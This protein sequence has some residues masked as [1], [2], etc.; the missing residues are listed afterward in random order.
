MERRLAAILSYDI[1]GYSRAMG[2]DEHGTLERLKAHRRDVIE[3]KAA[4]HGGRI[5]KLMG[6]GALMEFSSVVDAVGF[7]VQV[8]TTV[9]GRDADLTEDQRLRYRIGINIGDVIAE[10]DDIYGDGVNVAVRLERLAKAGGVCVRRNVRNQVRGKLALDFE[11][12]GEI[13]FKNIERPVRVF[14]LLMNAK[15]AALAAALDEIPPAAKSGFR[16]SINGALS[17]PDKPSI[18]V[19]PFDNMSGDPGQ[20]YF[21]DG[22]TEEIITMLG[23]CRWLFVVARNS[24][25]AYKGKLIDIRRIAEEL[26][27]RY[28]LEGSVRRSGSRIRIK[29]ELV[30]GRDGAHLWGER[31][32]RDISDIFDLQDEIASIIAGTLEPELSSIEGAAL[33]GR[34]TSDLNAWDCYQRGLWHLYHF[35]KGDLESA[36]A[37]FDRAIALDPSF[38]LAHAKLAYTHIQLGWYGRWEDRPRRIADAISIARQAISLDE[39]EPAARVS[40]GRALA[41]SGALDRGEEELRTAVALDP[42]FAQAHFALAQALCFLERPDE[43]I[44]EVNEAIQLSPRD[45][46]MW[47]FLNVRAI[48]H[49]QAGNLEAAEEDERTALRQPNTTFIPARLLAAILGRQG[50]R[51]EAKEA[52][53]EL[54]RLRPGYTCA[55][56][57]R[58]WYFGPRPFISERFIE[59]LL[60]DLRAAG[61]P[62]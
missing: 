15:A 56:A 2:A 26:R 22:V 28:V 44:R 31:Y 14:D 57:R 34:S 3:P 23:R 18:A 60:T 27:V 5:I 29:A 33:G 38:A 9:A 58:E 48:A 49:Y 21:S 41:L 39:R 20:E 45:P 50:R 12:R 54:E 19:L 25:F 13:G 61:L 37:L 24:T 43:A 8:Q 42:C 52:L 40:L 36:K 62:D 59:R 4:Q 30:D 32:D 55:E 53:A 11:D 51:D 6:D 46:H 10:G 7:A 16:G 17:F 47:T 35:K 1:V